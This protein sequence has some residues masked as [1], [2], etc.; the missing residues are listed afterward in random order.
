M[1]ILIVKLS[2][3]GDVV[4]TLPL[5]SD[6]LKHHSGAVIDW[7]VEDQFSDIPAMHQGVSTVISVAVRRW[8]KNCFFG[9]RAAAVLLAREGTLHAA[10]VRLRRP[11]Q[12]RR[13][14][15]ALRDGGVVWL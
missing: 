12:S 11:R 13:R 3:L 6:I 10:H 5:V 9:G 4:H 7:V 14:R 1:K 2:S 15:D 8:R